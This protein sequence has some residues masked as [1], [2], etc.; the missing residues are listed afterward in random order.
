M[1]RERSFSIVP[2]LSFTWKAAALGVGRADLIF[3]ENRDGGRKKA[4]LGNERSTG[5]GISEI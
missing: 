1:S 4:T 5:E 2:L 3:G